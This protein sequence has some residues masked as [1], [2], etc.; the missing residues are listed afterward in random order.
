[1][2]PIIIVPPTTWDRY[3]ISIADT[4]AKKSKCV[5]RK[6][7]AI[8]VRDRVVFSEGYNGPPRDIDLCHDGVCIWP[9]S[10]RSS[11]ADLSGCPAAH[12][13]ANAIFHAARLGI[14]T[15]GAIIWMNCCIPCK[16]CMAAI[17][18]AGISHIICVEPEDPKMIFYDELSK[19]YIHDSVIGVTILDRKQLYGA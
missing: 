6:V 10:N 15:R 5:S 18:N 7:G 3:F 9:K 4:V 17:I 19:Q 11:P 2:T 14:A 8:L 13:E 16:N 1:M 12:A